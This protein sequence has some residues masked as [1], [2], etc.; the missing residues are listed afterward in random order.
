MVYASLP[1][2]PGEVQLRALMDGLYADSMVW[3]VL[4]R[5]I[6]TDVIFPGV[7]AASTLFLYFTLTPRE[8]IV[9]LAGLA[10]AYLT[11]RVIKALLFGPV[12]STHGPDFPATTALVYAAWLGTVIAVLVRKGRAS[13]WRKGLVYILGCIIVMSGVASIVTGTNSVTAVAGAWLWGAAWALW[14]HNATRAV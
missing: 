11:D 14:L 9:P 12:D 8:S 7:V 4:D 3:G 10:G 2:C 6:G 13:S 5:M 1:L